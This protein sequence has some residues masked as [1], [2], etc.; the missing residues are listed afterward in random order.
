VTGA[1]WGALA[2][3]AVL[4]LGRMSVFM[5]DP[6]QRWGAFAPEEF[7]TR[8][9]CLSS[10]VHAA[11]L[12]RRG[13]ANIYD[14]RYGIDAPGGVPEFPS[15]IDTGPLTMDT[16]EYPPQF[17]PLPR[18]LL[19]VTGDFMAIRALWFLLTVASFVVTVAAVARWLGGD[20][21]R[22][23]RLLALPLGVSLPLMITAYFGNFQVIT[24][25]LA[26]LA[27]LAIVTGRTLRGAALLA[28]LIGAKIF[29]GILGLYLLAARRFAAAAWTAAFGVVYV[30]L[31]LAL[32]GARPFADFF[33]HHLP[34]LAS[35]E[36]FAFLSQPRASM[37][38]LG[39][40]G[41]PFKLRI[42]G[43]AGSEAD[44]WVLARQ[45]TWGYTLVVV[46]LAVWAGWRHAAHDD[47]HARVRQL[48]AWFGL[49]ALGALRSPYAPPEALIPVVWAL[50][51]QAAAAR[52]RR[53]VVLAVT[54]WVTLM[55]VLPEPNPVAATL[56]LALSATALAT[57]TWLV[58][59]QPAPPRP[60]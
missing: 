8:H 55:I 51:L 49:L 18:L 43:W 19:A 33:G 20:V 54:L 2:V 52:H 16:Y 5:A 14:D 57:A 12:A 46:A 41:L 42:A 11:E 17:L 60:A 1:L 36:T 10:Y 23:V 27:M 7:L 28:F 39:V 4:Q 3:L 24:M 26:V 13:D 34:R 45:L 30:L 35:G 59:R 32:F 15:A 44:A 22:R 58:L 9:N 48:G 29:P 40:F 53:E 31:T 37:S 38:N 21:G 50:A 6:L 56:S 25:A 47:P